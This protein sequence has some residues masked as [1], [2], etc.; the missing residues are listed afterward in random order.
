MHT[1]LFGTTNLSAALPPA[2]MAGGADVAA[3]LRDH[4]SRPELKNHRS[5]VTS[6]ARGGWS[7]IVLF[8]SRAQPALSR[9]SIADISQELGLDPLDAICEILLGEG[10]DLHALMVIAFAYREDDIRPAYEPPP[11]R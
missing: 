4:A 5:I 7:R 6:L 1:W 9:R 11:V 10:D 2:W 8:H 3:Q